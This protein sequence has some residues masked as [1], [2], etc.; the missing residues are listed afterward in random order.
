MAQREKRT[1]HSVHQAEVKGLYGS[2][3]AS[4]DMTDDDVFL[5]AYAHIHDFCSTALHP[6]HMP[7]RNMLNSPLGGRLQEK[8]PFL[9][10]SADSGGYLLSSNVLGRVLEMFQVFFT[11]S[12]LLIPTGILLFGQLDKSEKFGVVVASVFI[13]CAVV[14]LGRGGGG[15]KGE[16][17]GSGGH[18]N[19]LL[20]GVVAAYTAVLATFLAQLGS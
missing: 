7:V 11:S 6:V 19:G 15:G 16:A 17:G 9:K 12:L 20:H 2:F 13:F 8:I 14:V 4:Q 10:F 5:P 1:L 3:L 18:G